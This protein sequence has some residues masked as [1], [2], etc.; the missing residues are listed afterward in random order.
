MQASTYIPGLPKLYVS[1]FNIAP[2]AALD[3]IMA[4]DEPKDRLDALRET[5]KAAIECKRGY[6][7]LTFFL[8]V[9]KSLMF[10]R[11]I[12]DDVLHLLVDVLVF[13]DDATSNS[14]ADGKEGIDLE[15]WLSEVLV[16]VKIDKI[17]LKSPS[18][19]EDVDGLGEDAH[20][21]APFLLIAEGRQI[22]RASCRE[23][24]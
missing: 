8:D 15:G 14:K 5:M 23:R 12:R 13:M 22:G 3:M 16:S 18:S 21:I 10:Y 4:V 7:F 2:E 9:I 19:L 17:L 11:S 6:M 24:V 20:T 1:Y